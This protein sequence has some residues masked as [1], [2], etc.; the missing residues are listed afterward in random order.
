MCS[1]NRMISLFILVL[2]CLGYQNTLAGTIY[3]WTD[4]TGN[5]NFSD[6][7]PSD[8]SA[9]ET[10]E[11]IIKIAA[12][13]NVDFEQYSIINQAELMAEWRRQLAE[14]RLAKKK[15]YLEEKRLLH[16]L[17]LSKRDEIYADEY[18]PRAYYYNTPYQLPY[19]RHHGANILPH[20]AHHGHTINVSSHKRTTKKNKCC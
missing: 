5:I 12:V 2:G 1:R 6:V 4:E 20:P 15:L 11:F 9:T 16:E 7:P 19:R 13:N 18:V 10:H 3:Q 14:E 17:E 8:S